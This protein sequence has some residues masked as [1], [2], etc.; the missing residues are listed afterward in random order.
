MD[1]TRAVARKLAAMVAENCQPSAISPF[2]LEGLKLIMTEML[3]ARFE[4]PIATAL[5]EARREAFEEAAKVAEKETGDFNTAQERLM[6]GKIYQ[7]IR[8]QAEG[9]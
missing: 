4:S 5:A 8:Q 2:D 9:K 6:A 7:A 3:A 1:D